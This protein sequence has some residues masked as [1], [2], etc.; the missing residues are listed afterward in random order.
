MRPQAI[1]LGGS[2]NAAR[3]ALPRMLARGGGVIVNLSSGTARG[4]GRLE[5]L[6]RAR[7]RAHP[8]HALPARGAWQ[9]LLI[10]GFVAGVV[11]TDLLHAARRAFD[12][13]IA[14]L[15]PDLQHCDGTAPGPARVRTSPPGPP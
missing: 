1:N 13:R 14:R 8:A 11:V 6:P 5:R 12:N 7:G 9:G 2:A 15:S 4:R 10:R 3:A